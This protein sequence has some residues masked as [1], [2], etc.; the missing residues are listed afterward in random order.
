MQNL[1]GHNVPVMSKFVKRQN[2]FRSDG[3]IGIN[4]PF[5]GGWMVLTYFIFLY[6]EKNGKKKKR[7]THTDTHSI[8][9]QESEHTSPSP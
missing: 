3:W 1:D 7:H 5:F 6:V 9:N 8:S 2:S 4:L